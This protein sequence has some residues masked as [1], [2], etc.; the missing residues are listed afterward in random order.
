MLIVYPEQDKPSVKSR[1]LLR[2]Q[3]IAN[4]QLSASET[5]LLSIINDTYYNKKNLQTQL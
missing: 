3:L 1:D 5:T 2:F 4:I